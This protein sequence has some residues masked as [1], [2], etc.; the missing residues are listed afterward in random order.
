MG[1]RLGQH[2]LVRTSILDRIARVACEER[3]PLV[4][5]IGPGRGALTAYLVERAQRVVAVELDHILAAGLRLKFAHASQFELVEGDVLA[6]DLGQWGRAVVVGNLPYYITSPILE[7]ALA[8]G[9]LLKRAVFLMQKEVAQ[10]LVAAPGSRD[11]GYLSVRTQA[12]ADARLLFTVPPR[13]FQPPPKVDS[14]AVLLTM[15]Q[16]PLVEDMHGFLK[17]A[18]ACFH[19][20]RK[21]LRNNLTAVYGEMGDFA[22]ARLRAEQLSL[23]Q[24]ADLWRRLRELASDRA[25]GT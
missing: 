17:F 18:A 24:L 21:N 25:I 2:F 20:K 5:E 10:R 1:Q 16:T 4:V 19:Q 15:R 3:E 13:A 7:R 8:L 22:E 23:E 6:A 11:Y 9:P 14:G 12:Q